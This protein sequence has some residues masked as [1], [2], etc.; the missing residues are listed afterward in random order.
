MIS[1]NLEQFKKE[2]QQEMIDA[3]NQSQ[4]SKIFQKY[5]LTGD[6]FLTYKCILDITKIQF[7]NTIV[8]QQLQSSLQALKEQ[9]VILVNCD[10]CEYPRCRCC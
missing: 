5:G 4:L 7:V 2:I 8:S 10:C 1:E 9:E 3:L 6:Q